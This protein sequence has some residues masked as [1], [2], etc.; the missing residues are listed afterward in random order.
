MIFCLLL[1][2]GDRAWSGPDTALPRSCP[3]LHTLAEPLTP[4]QS[5]PFWLPLGHSFPFPHITEP[6]QLPGHWPPEPHTPPWARSH[7]NSQPP[8]LRWELLQDRDLSPH[9]AALG[10]SALSSAQALD[11]SCL[12]CLSWDSTPRVTLLSQN[13]LLIFFND[14]WQCHSI[15]PLIRVLPN[16]PKLTC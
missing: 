5:W 6:L 12:P 1:S 4:H 14:K 7:L 13:H 8:D 9:L 10:Q 16:A 15:K 2:A 3:V 11:S